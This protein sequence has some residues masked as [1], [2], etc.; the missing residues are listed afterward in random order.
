MTRKNKEKNRAR[1]KWFMPVVLTIQEAEIRK[2]IIQS[3]PL[4]NSL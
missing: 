2:I 1:Y 3:Q 4:A